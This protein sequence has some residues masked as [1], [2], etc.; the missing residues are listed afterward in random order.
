[1]NNSEDKKHIRISDMTPEDRRNFVDAFIWL[2]E[3][4]KKINYEANK[5]DVYNYY[6]QDK[7]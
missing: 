3:E 6:D 4:D 5:P 7:L 2:I 1:M